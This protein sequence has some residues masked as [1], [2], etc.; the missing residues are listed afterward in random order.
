[1]DERDK[2]LM[3]DF[4]KRLP[5]EAGKHLKQLI[6]FG[7]RARGNAAEDSYLDAIALVD[8]KTLEIEQKFDDIVYQVMWDHDF[9]PII[10]LKVFAESQFDNALKRGFSFYRYIEKEGISI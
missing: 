1:M 7:S 3:L 9:K 2:A 4:K 8:E 10:S 6:V 5:K